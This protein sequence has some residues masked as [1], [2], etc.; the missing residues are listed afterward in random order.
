[1]M[2]LVPLLAVILAL[3]FP[4]P[5][6]VSDIFLNDIRKDGRASSVAFLH[7][8]NIHWKVNVCLHMKRRVQEGKKSPV[9]R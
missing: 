3:L 9:V 5:F 1:M 4:L 7:P 8:L 2:V 6:Y